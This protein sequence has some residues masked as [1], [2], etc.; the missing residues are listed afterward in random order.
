MGT[1]AGYDRLLGELYNKLPNKKGGD[2]RFELPQFQTTNEG[3]KTIIKNFAQVCDKIRRKKSIV[4]KYLSKE[5]ASPISVDMNRAVIQ[6][7]LNV[8]VINKKLK[9]FF[10]RYVVCKE[11]NRPDTKMVDLGHGIKQIVCEAC[12]A[13]YTVRI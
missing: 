5:L 10:E 4:A 6:R 13:K 11:C 12:G 3:G 9:E 1:E 7:K 8:Q 2:V